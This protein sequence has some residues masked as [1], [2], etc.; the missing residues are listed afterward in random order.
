M[1]CCFQCNLHGAVQR[2]WDLTMGVDRC[3]QIAME[4]IQ[5]AN[6]TMDDG[7]NVIQ[8]NLNFSVCQG[9]IY[10]HVNQWLREKHAAET[11][12]WITAST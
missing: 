8:K 9:D 2:H 7:D 5:I 11:S 3:S 12:D 6:L 1:D 4:K 10:Y